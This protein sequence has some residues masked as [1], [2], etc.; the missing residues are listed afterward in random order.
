[1][2][3][4][5]FL[6]GG[7]MKNIIK[8]GFSSL[9]K[10]IGG[11]RTSDLILVASK[12]LMGKTAF[13]LNVIKHVAIEANTA[14]AIFSLEMS[15]EQ[16]VRR[17]LCSLAAIK[18]S[19][20]KGGTVSKKKWPNLK[21]AA[22]LLS[23]APIFIDDTPVMSVLD[24]KAKIQRLQ[25]KQSLGL[26]VIDY[27]QL[28][29]GIERSTNRKQ[30]LVGILGSLKTLA[31]EI[32]VTVIVI[33]QLSS[34]IAVEKTHSTLRTMASKADTVLYI[35]SEEIDDADKCKAE[36]VIDKNWN[37]H[38]GKVALAFRKDI[39]RFESIDA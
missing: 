25:K 11:L 8:T 2:G 9:D 38:T 16:I 31:K 17:M 21:D 5:S 4:Y 15:Q 24:I 19:T 12:P 30:E 34:K 28:L 33:V 23:E 6:L 26:V 22:D 20:L 37:K 10:I 3:P 35:E 1:M 39:A 27:L 13:A 36:I 18:T 7:I 29:Q 32:N 14:C